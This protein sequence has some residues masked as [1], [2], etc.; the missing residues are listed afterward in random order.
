IAALAP[1]AKNPRFA[2]PLDPLLRIGAAAMIVATAGERRTRAARVALTATLTTVLVVTDART[3]QRFFVD[4]RIYDPVAA[5]LLVAA[6]SLPGQP[7]AAVTPPSAAQYLNL[8]HRYYQL[9]DFPSAIR[10][11][12]QAIALDPGLADAYNNLGAS[13]AEMKEWQ[14]A[15]D[16]LETALRLRPDF[17]LARNNLTWAQAE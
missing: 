17:P 15:V 2:L 3:F 10:M 16:A 9:G 5:N 7:A 14:A 6:G 13:H 1:V 8:S 11:A 4:D 12:T